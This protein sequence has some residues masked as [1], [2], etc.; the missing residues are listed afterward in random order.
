MNVIFV[1]YIKKKNFINVSD[2]DKPIPYVNE[3]SVLDRDRQVRVK[4]NASLL[5]SCHVN[6]CPSPTIRLIRNTGTLIIS[7]T[8]STKWLNYTIA[9]SHCSDTDMYTCIGNS[10]IFRNKEN[11][12]KVN[13]TCK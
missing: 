7:K 11:T 1:V 8:D 9:S 6:G 3:L 4:E 2:L 5:L 13:V 12:F 10:T